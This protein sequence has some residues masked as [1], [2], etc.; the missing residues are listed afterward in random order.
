M[1]NEEGVFSRLLELITS[2]LD[3]DG[4]LHRMLLQ[5]LYEMSRIQRIRTEELGKCAMSMSPI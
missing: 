5:L 2:K 1:M 4:D 3:E